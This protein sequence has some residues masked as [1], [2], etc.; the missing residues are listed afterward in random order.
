ML[1][2]K[3]V[4]AKNISRLMKENNINR[5]KLSNDLKVKYTTLS[6]WINAKNY[7][8]IDKIEL[9]ADY[10]NVTKADL[11]EDKEQQVLE[12]LPVKKIPVV[13]KISAGLPI[14]SEENLIDYIYF[15]TNKLNSDKEEFGLKVSGDSMDKIFQDGDIVVVEKDSIVENGQLGVV[16]IN[17]YNATVKR[18]RYNGDQ[19]ILIPESNN[20]NHYPQVY[21]KDDEVKIIGRVVASQKL[22]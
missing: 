12:T 9:L 20:T 19:V 1:G 16:M 15:A 22:F 8:R 3:Q 11:V 4:M 2:N 14:Y 18:I 5:K 13:S 21:G 10:F 6:D 7:P 17:G